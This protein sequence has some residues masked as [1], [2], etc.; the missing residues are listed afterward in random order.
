MCE[1][2]F[3]GLVFY[4]LPLCVVA[5][6]KPCSQQTT[7]LVAL[8]IDDVFIEANDVLE[9]EIING[10]MEGVAISFHW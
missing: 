10:N 6:Y 5:S 4:E 8:S 7:D 3:D 9:G 1:R 2:G